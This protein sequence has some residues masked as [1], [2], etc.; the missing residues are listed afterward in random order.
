VY[1][2]T[3]E[4]GTWRD[5]EGV[6]PQWQ[7]PEWADAATD[8]PSTPPEPIYTRIDGPWGV[9]Y[10]DGLEDP[11]ISWHGPLLSS[12]NPL[13]W[14]PEEDVGA[15]EIVG[16]YDGAYRTSGPVQAWGLEPS[17]GMFDTDYGIQVNDQAI[18]RLMRF[19][20]NIPERWDGN[21]VY[22]GND[23][24]DELVALIANGDIPIVSDAEVTTNLTL[25]P[26][27]EQY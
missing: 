10:F 24:R 5:I 17:G 4:V 7:T 12:A 9:P 26:N 20:A 15:Q 14:T 1:L 27:V 19:P 16:A 13:P 22:T 8:Q 3:Y 25:W 23:Y 21:G 18:G 11:N 2:E 6:D